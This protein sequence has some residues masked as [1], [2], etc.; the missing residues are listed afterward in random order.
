MDD[1]RLI[2]LIR[3]YDILYDKSLPQYR[4]KDATRNAW[5]DVS[6]QCGIPVAECMA[7]WRSLRGS[8]TRECQKER[9]IRSGSG[10]RK[11]LRWAYAEQMSFLRDHITGK[12]LASETNVVTQPSGSHVDLE[13]EE[14]PHEPLSENL[15]TVSPKRKRSKVQE[16]NFDKLLKIVEEKPTD[17]EVFGLFIAREMNSLT[18]IQQSYFK[19]EVHKLIHNI[20]RGSSDSGNT[21]GNRI[22][23]M[24]SPS[25]STEQEEDVSL[26]IL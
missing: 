2:E 7:K 13:V 14:T 12:G 23:P 3:G 20:R 9:E 18:P 5:N 4:D 11:R 26:I 15:P 24:A 6:T 22:S 21:N 10:V 1:S 17:T 16:S 25:S 19:F 8:Y